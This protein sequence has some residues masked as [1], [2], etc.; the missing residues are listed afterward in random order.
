MVE[1]V[2]NHT[3]EVIII[4]EIG[5]KEEVRAALTCRERGVRIVASA[6]GDLTGLVRNTALCDLVGGVDVVTVGDKTAQNDAKF[7][8]S[9]GSTNARASKLRAERRGPPI[10]DVI[11]ELQRNQLHEWRVVLNT[12]A[13][14][15]SILTRG[16]YEAQIR[17][18]TA[19]SGPLQI[20]N[21]TCMS[22]REKITEEQSGR[23]PSHESAMT[24]IHG[25]QAVSSDADHKQCP[26]CF[27][28]F[29]S[30]KNMLQH[31]MTKKQCKNRLG[32]DR[33]WE[34]GKELVV[35]FGMKE[36]VVSKMVHSKK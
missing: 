23:S 22:D 28:S 20:Q 25:G 4:D 30:R 21:V 14:V 19:E 12:A 26:V 8:N 31:A 35:D 17:R 15:D 2:Q 6:H 13:A 5:R 27:S 11:V 36:Q 7:N 34:M 1:C 32:F 9:W 24:K 29:A 10:F 33:V 3:P 16:T 18:R